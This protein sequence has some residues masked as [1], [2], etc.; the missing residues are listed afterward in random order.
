MNNGFDL[1]IGGNVLSVKDE[2]CDNG[3]TLH[4][5]HLKSETG[6][7]IGVIKNEVPIVKHELPEAVVDTVDRQQEDAVADTVDTVDMQ[8]EEAVVDTVDTV[9]MQQE[10]AV[11]DN[12]DN[13][14]M[15]QEAVVDNMDMQQEEAVV[16]T[17]DTQQ[18]AVIDNVDTQQEEAVVD[19]VD[20]QQEETVVKE[21]VL[22]LE[23]LQL[24]SLKLFQNRMCYV[25]LYC[26]S[27]SELQI[28]YAKHCSVILRQLCDEV[29]RNTQA[30]VIAKRKVSHTKYQK[31][32]H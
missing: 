10:E 1:V 16:D 30:K 9:D 28:H 7:V 11:V 3:V 22:K 17:V 18:E 31:V 2:S 27:A 29:S 21:C 23:C 20:M 12:M 4:D 19:N 13:V 6:P 8:Q 32:I 14:D 25:K 15:Q 5:K 26:L 24:G